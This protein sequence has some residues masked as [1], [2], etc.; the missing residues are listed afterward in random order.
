MWGCN[1]GKLPLTLNFSYCCSNFS[2]HNGSIFGEASS[3]LHTKNVPY[4]FD[5][6]HMFCD[7]CTASGMRDKNWTRNLSSHQ[8]TDKLVKTVK[9]EKRSANDDLLHRNYIFTLIVFSRFVNIL[10]RITISIWRA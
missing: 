4:I 7:K 1:T 9:C 5:L 8:N 3:A 6:R 10:A 2:C